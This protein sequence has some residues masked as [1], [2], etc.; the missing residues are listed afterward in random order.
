MYS[1]ALCSLTF[2]FFVVFLVIWNQS[3]IVV[4]ITYILQEIIK[5][6]YSENCINRNFMWQTFVFGIY[7]CSVYTSEL[8]NISYFRTFGLYQISVYSGFGISCRMYVIL[9]TMQLW[10]QMFNLLSF[11]GSA[12]LTLVSSVLWF[13]VWSVLFNLSFQVSAVLT[14]VSSVLWFLVWFVLFN[15]VFSVVLCWPSTRTTLKIIGWMTQHYP[16]NLEI[17]QHGP[18]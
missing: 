8:K 18:H 4:N 10:F 14:L 5:I 6:Q 15:Q 12:V 11:Q 3:C 13:L 9:T 16:E 17:E 2:P 7:R 1:F